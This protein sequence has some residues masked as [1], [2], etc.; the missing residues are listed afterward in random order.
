VPEQGRDRASLQLRAIGVNRGISAAGWLDP[1]LLLP[2]V[3]G[4]PGGTVM[5]MAIEFQRPSSSSDASQELLEV[6]A[7]ANGELLGVVPATAR[8][9][10]GRAVKA[11][12]HAQAIWA[13][14]PV[15]ERIE[16]LIRFR[17]AL[18]ERAEEVVDL[19]SRESG[20]P[21][22][23][24]L[25]HEL[26][27]LADAMSWLGRNAPRA[28]APR[29]IELHL[30][31]HRRSEV[32]Y[33]PRRVSAVIAPWNFPLLIPFGD[34]FATLVTGSS[35]IVKPSELT[36]LIALLVKR[37]WDGTG[38]PEDL[39]QVLPGGADTGAALIDAGVDQVLFTGGV[40]AGR[41]VSAACGQRLLPCVLELGGKAP[42]VVADDV[43]VERAARA[44][45][46]GGFA[47]SGQICISVERV[48]VHKHVYDQVVDRVTELVGGL[49][50]GDPANGPVDVG[51]MVLPRQLEHCEGLVRDAL[52]R[53][54]C[55]RAGGRRRR[56]PGSFFEPTVLADCTHEMAVMKQEIFGP[57]VPFMRVESDEQ[58]IELANDS[59]L[60]LNAYVFARDRQRARGIAERIE[61]GS[62]VV[63]DVITN[64]ACPEVPFGG[65]KQSGLG[66]VHGE[67][68]LR[69]LCDVKHLS[70]DRIAAPSRDPLWFPYSDK[71]YRFALRALRALYSGGPVLARVRELL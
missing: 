2:I 35:V 55:L 15:E 13:L 70:F 31:K 9:E 62:V 57:I 38:L 56:G 66:R 47:N 33:A 19:L 22:Q 41:K 36:P 6:R 68:A 34:A 48:Y 58:A 46:F 69:A 29:S 49:R 39:L 51:A 17:D 7:P 37:V 3:L 54:A 11:A 67:D 25:T 4:S 1:R 53:G 71:G 23:E 24:A 60:G 20:K 21:R 5:T 44:I 10:V 64:Y 61:A 65:V 16:R 14:L 43:D 40:G 27:P 12:R 42:L 32:G 28:L 30:F 50:Q 63:N 8:A 45:V 18:V 26:L 52:E 59:E